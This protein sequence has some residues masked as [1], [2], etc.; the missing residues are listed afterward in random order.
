[1]TGELPAFAEYHACSADLGVFNRY[2]ERL[3]YICS[4]GERSCDVALYYPV[5]D[6]WGGIRAEA[7]AEEFDAA[8][9]EMESRGVDFD[10]VDDDV[11]AVSDC[12]DNGLIRM[13]N[14]CY[15]KIVLPKSAYLPDKTAALLER[16]VRGGGIVT[17]APD[18]IEPKV[19]LLTGLGKTRTMKRQLENGELICLYNEDVEKKEI[20]VAVREQNACFEK[21]YW[22]DV[23]EGRVFRL[24]VTD[25]VVA[26]TLESGETGA[27]FLT[28]E[29]VEC[30]VLLKG[31]VFEELSD[32]TFRRTNSFVIGEKELETHDIE[33]EAR[34]MELGCWADRVGI[35]FS[36]SGIYE[37][38]FRRPE[39]GAVLELGDVRYTCEVF[40]NDQS[41]GV[42]VMPPY[43]YE[44][45]DALLLDDN[46]LAIRVSNTPGNQYQFTKSLDKW[47]KWQLTPYHE[48]Q[49]LF[50]RDTLD[51]GLYGP[52]R[53]WY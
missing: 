3:S 17:D 6:Y 9:K 32:F 52:V 36:G 46:K 4:I 13:G 43:R 23:T 34:P 53:L 33:E 35:D 11:I 24:T 50:D 5:N 15:R 38:T 49:L 44:L 48:R 25:G 7:V 26:V 37:T 29:E 42:K 28:A 22:M 2:L 40:L 20:K 8:G 21:A 45:P 12:I 41:L 18:T 27:V 51:S 16:F 1:M 10:I 14:A 31:T 30:D 47:G 19:K 39:A